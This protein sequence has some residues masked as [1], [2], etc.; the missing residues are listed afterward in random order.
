MQQNDTTY[1]RDLFNLS[2]HSQGSGTINKVTV[3]AESRRGASSGYM[4]I[5]LKS[6]TTTVE[7]NEISLLSSYTL[8][9]KEW[10]LNPDT[11]LAW[12]WADI[13]A[14]QIGVALRGFS[15][16]Y[17]GRCTQLYVEV[18]YTPAEAV[19]RHGFTCFQNPGVV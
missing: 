1:K 8:H 16:S 19:P 6:G 3:Y 12:T 2:A 13:D 18:D 9:G 14:L 17:W 7:G 11:S 5:A 15:S 4:K 10:A